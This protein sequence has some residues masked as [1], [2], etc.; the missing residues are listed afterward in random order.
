[1]HAINK[2]HIQISTHFKTNIYTKQNIIKPTHTQLKS[3]KTN[4]KTQPHITNHTTHTYTHTHNNSHIRKHPNFKI[5]TYKQIQT[6]QTP[7]IQT[8]TLSKSIHTDTKILQNHT[9]THKHHHTSRPTHTHK[10]I[11][12]KN[13]TH[14]QNHT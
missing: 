2:P 8:S 9:Y 1:M 7:Q 5:P 4:N 11:Y 10:P 6:L 13:P 14:P 12:I 3:F